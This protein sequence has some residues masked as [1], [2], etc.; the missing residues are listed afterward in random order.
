VKIND[1]TLESLN[2]YILFK[3]GT[4]FIVGDHTEFNDEDTRKC[5]SAYFSLFK[6]E[7]FNLQPGD[8]LRMGSL[9]FQM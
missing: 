7:K 8:I 9:M 4:Y 6:D 5:E 3:Y 2:L 1:A